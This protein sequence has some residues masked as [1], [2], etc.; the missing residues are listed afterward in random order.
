MVLGKFPVY[1]VI[2]QSFGGKIFMA[3]TP[4]PEKDK[5]AFLRRI[6]VGFV[7]KRFERRVGGIAKKK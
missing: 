2:Y 5:H 6:I 4:A 7:V 1:D 3:S